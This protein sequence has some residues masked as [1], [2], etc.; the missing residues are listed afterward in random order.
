[1]ANRVSEPLPLAKLLLKPL[2]HF[3]EIMEDRRHSDCGG[4]KALD[5]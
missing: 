4:N 5:I 1:M 3:A 2:G